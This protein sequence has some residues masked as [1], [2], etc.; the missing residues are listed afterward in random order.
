VS[1]LDALLKA[2]DH[3]EHSEVDDL[4]KV[5]LAR[6]VKAVADE[7]HALIHEMADRLEA[8]EKEIL[9]IVEAAFAAALASA[10]EKETM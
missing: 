6:A 7:A 3:I 5:R 2:C 1:D 10:Q 8:Q 9:R 4:E